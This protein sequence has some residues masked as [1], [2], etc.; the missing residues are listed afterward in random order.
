MT[1]FNGKQMGKDRVNPDDYA[2]V[3]RLGTDR[4][5]CKDDYLTKE[6]FPIKVEEPNEVLSSRSRLDFGRVFTVEHNIKV[7]RVGRIPDSFLPKLQEY[8]RESVVD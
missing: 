5:D 3:Y 6:A 4:E 7:L 1:T 2:A 8:Y